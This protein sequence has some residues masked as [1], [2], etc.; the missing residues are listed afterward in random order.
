MLKT[1]EFA[2]F[3]GHARPKHAWTV[4]NMYDYSVYKKLERWRPSKALPR[5]FDQFWTQPFEIWA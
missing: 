4:L 5:I 1:E 3:C 2:G